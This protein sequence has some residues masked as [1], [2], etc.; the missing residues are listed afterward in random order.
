MPGTSKRNAHINDPPSPFPWQSNA[1]CH[2]ICHIGPWTD[3][4]KG[5]RDE[6]AQC[7]VR[8]FSDIHERSHKTHP[9]GKLTM[10]RQISIII[11]FQSTRNHK[12]NRLHRFCR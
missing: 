7:T 10:R 3:A 6:Q 4:T 11:W 2:N 5:A 12:E 8:R 1:V 9:G